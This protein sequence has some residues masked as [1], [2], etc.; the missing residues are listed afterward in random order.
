MRN[1]SH[2][3]APSD[4]LTALSAP[5]LELQPAAI[6]RLTY[7]SGDRAAALRIAGCA[8]AATWPGQVSAAQHAV[9]LRRDR[10]LVVNG[11]ELAEGWHEETGLAISDATHALTGFDL[12][13]ENAL[14][15]LNTLAEVDPGSPSQ[16]CTRVLNG[17]S[18]ILYRLGSDCAFRLFLAPGSAPAFVQHLAARVPG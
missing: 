10:I 1:D 9:S 18:A 14:R 2:T 16:G 15:A 8:D 6:Q 3:W 5:G 12:S 11:P 4:R 7:I 17:M 13:G